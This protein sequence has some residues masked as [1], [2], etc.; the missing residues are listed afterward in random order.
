MLINHELHEAEMTHH[1]PD[2]TTIAM[3]LE[4]LT[5]HGLEGVAPAVEIL[6]NQ[7]MELERSAF[8]EAAPH[9]RTDDRKGYANGFRA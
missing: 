4:L 9:E 6:I 7:A 5:E 3:A 1:T 8:L 2:A